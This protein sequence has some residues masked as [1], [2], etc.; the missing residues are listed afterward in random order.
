MN[1]PQHYRDAEMCVKRAADA[2]NVPDEQLWLA[3]A[4]VHATLA[5]AA[6]TAA[7]I[8]RNGVVFASSGWAEVLGEPASGPTCPEHQAPALQWGDVWVCSTGTEC[9]W[10]QGVGA[11]AAADR[12]APVADPNEHPTGA[13]CSDPWCTDKDPQ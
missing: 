5:L 7:N 12:L 13:P 10:R 11:R 6:A 8:R 2:A 3:E 1:G 4:Q 9:E